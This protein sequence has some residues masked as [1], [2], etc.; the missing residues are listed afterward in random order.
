MKRIM[1]ETVTCSVCGKVH[2]IEDSEL[3]FELPDIIYALAQDEREKRCDISPDVCA[4]DRERFFLRGLLP[5][6]VSGHSQPYNIGVWAEISVETFGRIHGRWDDPDQRDE[7]RLPGTLANSVP[8]QGADTLG[9]GVMIQLIGTRS[10]PEFYV[11][12]DGHPLH[13]EQT[14]GIDEHRAIQYSTLVHQDSAQ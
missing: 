7:P 10:R 3:T 5:I 6:P 1:S 12:M 11:E 8:L 13:R 9:T 2:A 4:L 14:R